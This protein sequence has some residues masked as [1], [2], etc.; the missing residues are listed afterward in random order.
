NEI[1][2]DKGRLAVVRDMGE[3]VRKTGNA[4]LIDK[5]AQKTALRLGVSSDAARA[6]FKKAARLPA[7]AAETVAETIDQSA[8]AQR[9]SPHEYQLLKLI[10]LHE[11]LL[12]WT[13][14]NLDPRWIQ[15]PLVQQIVFKRLEI[16]RAQ[17]WENL[18]TFLNDLGSAEI[19]NL[20]T[21][22]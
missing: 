16:H 22:A 9:P 7:P 14:G 10:L 3:A 5:Y 19:Q 6:E 1:T 13:T 2:T 17:T 20:V 11:D 18:G 8:P 21:E 12:E 15:H 4:V